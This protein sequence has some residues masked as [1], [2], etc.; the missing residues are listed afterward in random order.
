VCNFHDGQSKPASYTVKGP[1]YFPKLVFWP[2]PLV[3]GASSDSNSALTAA[4]AILEHLNGSATAQTNVLG[5]LAPAISSI[6]CLSASGSPLW[7]SCVS[8]A[9]PPA[10]QYDQNALVLANKPNNDGG[11]RQ[12][13]KGRINLTTSGSGAGHLITLVDSNV[14]KTIATR[15]NR[16]EN[17]A[18]DT[19][20]GYDHTTGNPATVGLSLGAPASISSYVGNVGD[21]KSWKERLTDKQKTFAVPVV[22]ESG[23]TLTVGGGSA[24][25]QMK[26]FTTAP[27]PGANV[28]AQSCVDVKGSAKGLTAADQITGIAPPKALGNLALNAYASGADTVVLHFCNASTAGVGVP[29]GP[30]KFLA[31]R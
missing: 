15:N 19:Y 7:M 16:P 26:M 2:G 8:G 22:V 11:L 17:D 24:I 1:S 4:T 21:D 5:P 30:Y 12:N 28:P 25:S 13:M 23:S 6:D 20:I 18:Q 3:L 29:A 14:Q 10:T 27:V 31:V 9:F